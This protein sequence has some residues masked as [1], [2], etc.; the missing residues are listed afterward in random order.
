MFPKREAE[1]LSQLT[2][3]RTCHN[4]SQHAHEEKYTAHF[5][6]TCMTAFDKLYFSL[7]IIAFLYARRHRVRQLCFLSKTSQIMQF[8]SEQ[9]PFCFLRL[10]KFQAAI[11][12]QRSLQLNITK[13]M[14][15][16]FDNV[17]YSKFKFKKDSLQYLSFFK[18]Y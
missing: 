6:Q 13:I 1:T 10:L 4:S 8:P 3:N 16:I 12:S 11:E 2:I 14:S 18:L 17:N 9:F 5:M 7:R 15:Q